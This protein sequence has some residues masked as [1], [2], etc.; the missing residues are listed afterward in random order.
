MD[1]LL[2]IWIHG[3]PR[4]FRLESFDL[5]PG[6]HIRGMLNGYCTPLEHFRQE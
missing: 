1:G 2:N 3:R 5:V 6:I 4:N